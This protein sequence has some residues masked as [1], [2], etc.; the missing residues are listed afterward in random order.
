MT[1]DNKKERYSTSSKGYISKNFIDSL[2]E[3][4]MLEDIIKEFVPLKREGANYKGRSPFVEERTPSFVVSPS[5][6]IWKDFSSGKGGNNAISFLMEMGMS[7]LEAIEYVAKKQGKNIQ[8][9]NT[10]EAK[11]YQEKLV[12]VNGLRPVLKS[13]IRLYQKT[14]EDL[15]KT[16]P[17]KVE[18][19]D[20]RR[21]NQDIVDTYQIGYAPGN[22]FIYNKLK[23]HGLAAEGKDASLISGM[24][25]FYFNRVIYTI[26]DAIGS[27][28]GLAGRDVS[29]N[30]KVKWLNPRNGLLYDKDV[31]WYGLH[32]AKQETRKTNK[33][34]IVEGYNDV[35]AFQSHGLLNAVSPCGTSISENQ[36]KVLKKYTN[37]VYFAM[38]GDSAGQKSIKKNIPRFIEAG[39]RCYAII[40]DECDPDDFV[41]KFSEDIEK[42]G[43]EQA[44]ETHT[45]ISEGFKI[46][47]D[48]LKNK[49]DVTKS[50]IAKKLCE[51]IA[52]ISDDSIVSIYQKWL[53]K[54]S[55]VSITDIKKWVK[56]FRS[57]RD[58]KAKKM[59]LVDNQYELP[60]GV[61]ATESILN[62][63]K[64]YQMFQANNQIWVQA[65]PEPPYSF[66]S[67]S[68]FSIEII[69]H[70]NDEKFPTKLISVQNTSNKRKVFDVKSS[71]MNQPQSFETV[72]TNHGNF[73]WK[74]NRKEHEL[75][76][77][78]L[79][80]R[81]GV[82][83]KIDVLGWQP[84]GFWVWN[85]RVSVPRKDSLNIDVN[86]VFYINETCYYVPSANNVYRNNMVM[87]GA[88]KKMVYEKSPFSFEHVASQILKVHREH[89]IVGLLFTIASI[90][91]DVVVDEIGAFPLLFLYGPASSGKDQL[92][93]CCRSFFGKP[94]TAIN[95]EGN[96]STV[97]AK[98][99]E[100]AQFSNMICELSEYKPGNSD[101]DGV[102]KG[103]Y[104]REGYK[105]G[106]IDSLYSTESVP[107]TS[108]AIVTGNFIPDQE[109]LITRKIWTNLD[110]TIFINEETKEYEKLSDMLK[111]GISSLTEMFL[112]HRNMVEENFKHKFR[113]FKATLGQRKAETNSRMLDNLSV[114]GAF[115]QLFHNEVQFPFTHIEM[116]QHFEKV[117]DL[118]MNKLTSSSIINRWW[119]CF[120]A[121]MRGTVSDQIL[122]G[123]DFKLEGNRFS[124]N[125]TSCY[126]RVSRQWYSQYKDSAPAKGVM[127]D[128]LRKDDSWVESVGATRMA[129]GRNSRS[130]SAYVVDINKIAVS[131]EI[132]S[133][134]EF[135]AYENSCLSP[136]SI[137]N[138]NNKED[139]KKLPF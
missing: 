11:A 28:I 87:Y 77:T 54:E 19:F 115:Y 32:I 7:F 78:C 71:D 119:D 8:Y 107:I 53:Q 33:V 42:K 37:I 45:E 47:L 95:L 31:T 101:L 9:E 46:L 116:M 81:M 59:Q 15:P 84:E 121:S 1:Q 34:Y 86:G 83:R 23:E 91:Q 20:Q 113:E 35:I 90:F 125:F 60:K 103:I 112:E 138:K 128:A 44:L 124:F 105:R 76:K 111:K 127:M 100:F 10:K 21:Y 79:F 38:D 50:I 129:P 27:P 40:F 106:T 88:Q 85:N 6:Q 72:I 30:P 110:K 51:L 57:S 104:G 62:D 109:A 64:R 5:K 137:K 126:L 135:Q 74:G 118:Q 139:N 14:F 133:A 73:R 134:I 114:L 93:D 26:C 55:S 102:L 63:I 49:D 36:I 130:T 97:K 70:M 96:A 131:D 12:K 94:Q 25:D 122:Y 58:Q 67:V 98:I 41:R 3:D 2:L 52:E 68:N 66:K 43:L 117:I 18:V 82:G 17:A 56:E 61:E 29:D 92:S 22:K 123:R 99:R 120:L 39:F 69:Q 4:T 136:D 48:E 89:A 65:N 132:K 75:L 108:S 24:E 16:H 80:D 13:V